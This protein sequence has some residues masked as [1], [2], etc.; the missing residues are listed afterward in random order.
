[1]FPKRLSSV[2]AAQIGDQTPPPDDTF[3]RR[4][5]PRSV[6]PPSRPIGL[7]PVSPSDKGKWWSTAYQGRTFARLRVVAL[8][9]VVCSSFPTLTVNETQAGQIRNGRRL[10][11]V[12]LPDGS[13]A[14]I[15]VAEAVS[16]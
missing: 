1:L 15:D 8:D 9:R 13:T 7:V 10:A 5:G 16:V 6:S 11:G 3:T 4:T 12:L 2:N 14:L